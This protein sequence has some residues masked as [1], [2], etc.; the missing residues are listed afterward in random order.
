[1]IRVDG[2]LKFKTYPVGGIVVEV[3]DVNAMTNV[4]IY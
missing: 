2:S 1:M 4:C 3:L